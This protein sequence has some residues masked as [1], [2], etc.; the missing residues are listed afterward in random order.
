MPL[1]VTNE[2]NLRLPWHVMLVVGNC[3]KVALSHAIA[4]MQ[5]GGP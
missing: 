1:L 3:C 5:D 4:I 2:L